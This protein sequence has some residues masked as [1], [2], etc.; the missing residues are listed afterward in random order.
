[1]TMKMCVVGVEDPTRI[2]NIR[3]LTRLIP[4]VSSALGIEKKGRRHGEERRQRKEQIF[5]NS[6]LL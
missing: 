4:I 5:N 3:G 2:Q 1:M 6:V